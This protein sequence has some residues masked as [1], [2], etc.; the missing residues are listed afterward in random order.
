MKKFILP[1]TSLLAVSAFSIPQA[2][3]A[4]DVYDNYA[5]LSSHYHQG[6]T[7][8]LKPNPRQTM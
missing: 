3:A 8:Q 4:S 5:E 2:F 6:Q 1:L 7:I